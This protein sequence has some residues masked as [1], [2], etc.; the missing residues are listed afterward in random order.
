[1]TLTYENY[2]SI[3]HTQLELYKMSPTRLPGVTLCGQ[4]DLGQYTT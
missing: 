1:M 4:R 3:N 2:A